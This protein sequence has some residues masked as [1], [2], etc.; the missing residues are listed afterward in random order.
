MFSIEH[1]R[2]FIDSYLRLFLLFKFIKFIFVSDN[3]NAEPIFNKG[4]INAFLY[5][6]LTD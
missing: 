2:K 5:S 4:Y 1:K 3:W 6:C